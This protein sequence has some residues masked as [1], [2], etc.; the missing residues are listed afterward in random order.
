M[1][2][3]KKTRN[4]YNKV[5]PA[6]VEQKNIFFFYVFRESQVVFKY[7]YFVSDVV[8]EDGMSAVESFAESNRITSSE[9][10]SNTRKKK[11]SE[12]QKIDILF[13]NDVQA[14]PIFLTNSDSVP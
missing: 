9:V 13:N 10:Y 8:E 11:Y 14:S 12:T 3:A 1:F 5:S 2:A 7:W 4:N 6:C